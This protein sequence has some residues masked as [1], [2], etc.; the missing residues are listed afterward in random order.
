MMLDKAV[1]GIL[2]KGFGKTV[3]SDKVSHADQSLAQNFQVAALPSSDHIPKPK[4]SGG[5]VQLF[6][7]KL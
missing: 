4:P 6:H 3:V 2:C 5:H 7:M 1:H